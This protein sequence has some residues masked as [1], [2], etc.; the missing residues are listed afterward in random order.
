MH[1]KFVPFPAVQNLGPHVPFI[2]FD[3]FKELGKI[4]LG[5]LPRVKP[6]YLLVYRL[7]LRGLGALF[8]FG[9]NKFR[10]CI[11][12]DTGKFFGGSID[13]S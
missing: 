8:F 12:N 4:L 2:R 3:R 1:G 11:K 9:R 13:L 6:E 10:E 5:K 7:L